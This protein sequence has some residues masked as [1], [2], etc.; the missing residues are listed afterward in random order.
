MNIAITGATSHIA[1]GLIIRFL[2]NPQNHLY[3]FSRNLEKVRQF[4]FFENRA[5][6]VNYSLCDD[7]QQFTSFSFDVIINCIG[8]ETRN[9]HNC[10]FTRYFS[11]TEKFDNLIIDY[12]KNNLSTL[13]ISFSSG[14]IYGADFNTPADCNSTRKLLVNSMREEEYYGIARINAEAKHRAY[15]SLKIIDLRVFSYFSRYIN[16]ND[17]YLI[18][19]IIKAII[20][21]KILITNNIDITRDYLHPDDL[22]AMIRACINSGNRNQA[23]DV[24]SSHTISKWE[25]IDLFAHEYGLRYEIAPNLKN[26]SATGTKINY[27]SKCKESAK[28]GFTPKYSSHETLKLES[29]YIFQQNQ[30]TRHQEV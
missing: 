20:E 25:I 10:D 23:F 26:V 21:D 15:S 5:T 17:G 4:L 22:F 14:A 11:V 27:F 7:Y 8:V 30:T 9:K 2:D 1:K 12:L 13:Y 28:I 18:T 16:L 29:N 6:N 24:N 19:D 3:L